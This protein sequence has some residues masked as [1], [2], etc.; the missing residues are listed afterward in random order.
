LKALRHSN[1]IPTGQQ[2]QLLVTVQPNRLS[3]CGIIDRHH[4][5]GNDARNQSKT[6]E[7]NTYRYPPWAERS[8]R[9]VARLDKQAAQHFTFAAGLVA[10]LALKLHFAYLT[11]SADALW[12]MARISETRPAWHLL[13]ACNELRF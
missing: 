12:L 8:E 3:T 10:G 7:R 5:P 11:R 4:P 2:R 6:V 13:S 9:S 1:S